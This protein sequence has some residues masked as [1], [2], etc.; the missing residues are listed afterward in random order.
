MCSVEVFSSDVPFCVTPQMNTY[1]GKH[2]KL[3]SV[4]STYVHVSSSHSRSLRS[5]GIRFSIVSKLN[6]RLT[7]P[8]RPYSE[9]FN[10]I[11]VLYISPKT[12]TATLTGGR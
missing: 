11:C 6:F 12:L 10:L 9:K 2:R 1:A 3:Y 7:K 4:Y 8:E 5:I